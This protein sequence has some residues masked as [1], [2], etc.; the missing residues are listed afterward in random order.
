[1]QAM[2]L[3]HQR[4]YQSD[5][6]THIEMTQYISELINY[7]KESFR[8]KKEIKFVLKIESLELD[9][10]QAVPL[11]LIINEAVT[12]AMKY[13]FPDGGLGTI[14][15]LLKHINNGQNELIISD[16]GI[17]LPEDFDIEAQHDSLGLNLIRGL[18]DQI[19][20]E[21]DIKSDNGTFLR[22]TFRET[23]INPEPNISD[24][25]ENSFEV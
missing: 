4:L 18:T 16:N 15:M 11:G 1:M 24:L 5:N 23:L 8:E 3:I 7:L 22:I 12:N 13:A 20:G 21:L 19:N 17:G 10:A 14:S 2:S 25:Q 9:I 6:L